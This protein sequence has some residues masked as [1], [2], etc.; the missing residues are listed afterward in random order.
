MSLSLL[1]LS[2][3]CSELR[4]LC[5]AV[6]Q[7]AF[8]PRER[9][10]FLE[11][12]LP[13]QTHLLRIDATPGRTRLH[14][15]NA[16]PASPHEPLALQQAARAHLVG[17]KLA[18]ID[19]SPNDRLVTLR[20]ADERDQRTLVAELTGRHGNLFLLA[21]SG[22]ILALGGPNLSQVRPLAPGRP[23]LPPASEPPANE[24]RT[25]FK[26]GAD[27]AISKQIDATY[28]EREEELDAQA[29]RARLERPLRTRLERLSRTVKKVESEAARTEIAER[30]RISGELLKTAL[31]KVPRGA[32]QA[33]LTDY[34]SG[35][36]REIEIALRPELSPADNLAWHF[37]QYRRL[38]QG[39]ARASERL[40]QLRK[41]QGELQAQLAQLAA[42]EADALVEKAAQLPAPQ[43]PPKKGQPAERKPFREFH[44]ANGARIW[45]GKGAAD[46]DALTF[47]IA[48]PHDLWLH[49]RGRTGAHVI[50][51]MEKREQIQP[52]VLLD[53]C[54]LAVH[55]S[56]ARTESR[57]EVS[58]VPRKY[59]RKAKGAAPGAVTY[60][61]ER[62]LNFVV[63]PERLARLLA[64]AES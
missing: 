47:K 2:Q 36:P 11:L 18:G 43:A 44:S 30:H 49:A 53:A 16:R 42:L 34:S 21:S 32:R 26:P 62:T 14:L 33:T 40:A 46:N 38:L 20:F 25:R 56:D 9:L 58:H 37:R 5:G 57:A 6:V 13:G 41:E 29:L 64:T 8:V 60:T 10:L 22:N 51:P 54:A 17:R 28:A 35:A 3:V 55:F 27:F 31:A 50:V 7:N 23:Y 4:L 63:E 1:E 52:E 19:L 61:Q 59:L 45:V 15:A 39:S 48:R 12:R 24:A